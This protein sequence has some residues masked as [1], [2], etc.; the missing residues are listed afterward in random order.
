MVAQSLDKELNK[1]AGYDGLP[2][3]AFPTLPTLEATEFGQQHFVT[4]FCLGP[5][6]PTLLAP[7][8][9][10]YPA[11]VT[12]HVIFP[13][14]YA[15]W[16]PET[17]TGQYLSG[18]PNF[19]DLPAPHGQILAERTAQLAAR[20]GVAAY[21]AAPLGRYL[22]LLEQVAANGWLLGENSNPAAEKAVA[23]QL[24]QL[25][26]QLCEPE[27]APYYR[28][29]ARVLREWIERVTYEKSWV[30]LAV[31]V[32]GAT[33]PAWASQAPGER[34]EVKATAP[35]PAVL[36][37]RQCV[38]VAFYKVSEAATPEEGQRVYP[39][40]AACYVAYPDFEVRWRKLNEIAA[41][42]FAILPRD[43][44]GASY[45]GTWKTGSSPR[46]E[47]DKARQLHQQTASSLLERGWLASRHRPTAAEQQA[48]QTLQQC[49]KALFAFP[50]SAY[51]EHTA[52]Q[53]LGWQRRVLSGE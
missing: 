7:A 8:G 41:V 36:D 11:A 16:Q 39:P 18:V 22:Q 3:H 50:L 37:G 10:R 26:D 35:I 4:T 15:Y 32:V 28:A 25:L 49:A 5:P 31:D 51:Y 30:E 46:P 21:P 12:L 6:P 27:L 29:R 38:V 33:A 19:E 23:Q 2:E 9:E 53:L 13:E 45:L 24:Q 52:W 44:Q 20:P 48:A 17:G 14:G 40:F 1:L 34:L 43:E 42:G 47:E